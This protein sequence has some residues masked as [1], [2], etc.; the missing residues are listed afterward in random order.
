MS[1]SSIVSASSNLWYL[2]VIGA[3]G[4]TSEFATNL[5]RQTHMP[6]WIDSFFFSGCDS[7]IG[8]IVYDLSERI[9]ASMIGWFRFSACVV[10]VFRDK[11]DD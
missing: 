9:F 8:A 4:G 10:W 2:S 3:I 11:S 7:H 1:C 5:Y 6:T